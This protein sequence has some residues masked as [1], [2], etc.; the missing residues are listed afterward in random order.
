M[1]K[2]EQ[3]RQFAKQIAAQA[4]AAQQGIIPTGGFLTTVNASAFNPKTNRVERIKLPSNAIQWLVE[5][6]T[7]QGN[8]LQEVEKLP[9]DSQSRILETPVLQ[10]PQAPVEQLGPQV[11]GV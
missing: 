1:L 5:Q 8:V 6:L 10:E 9:D 2:L 11:Q 3:H 7:N 4:L